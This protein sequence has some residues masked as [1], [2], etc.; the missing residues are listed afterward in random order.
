MSADPLNNQQRGQGG[1]LAP[2][3]NS[4]GTA[5][6]Q[7][8]LVEEVVL[9]ASHQVVVLDTLDVLVTGVGVQQREPAIVYA[10]F[11]SWSS[12]SG[13]ERVVCRGSSGRIAA[14]IKVWPP[15]EAP[16]PP[17]E[18]GEALNSEGWAFAILCRSE[19]PG[20][21]RDRGGLEPDGNPPMQSPTRLVQGQ[22]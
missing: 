14:G 16:A 9:G 1:I 4:L 7:G 11:T 12:T 17:T 22:C 5:L 18:S 21:E 19:C 13:E 10:T 8:V 3:K 6:L 20:P 15:L 2:F